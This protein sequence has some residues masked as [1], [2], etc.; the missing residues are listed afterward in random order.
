MLVLI[1]SPIENIYKKTLKTTYFS[2]KFACVHAHSQEINAV[3]RA[4]MLARRQSNVGLRSIAVF[5]RLRGVFMRFVHL[6]CLYDDIANA[7]VYEVIFVL[8]FI[9]GVV[10]C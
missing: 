7:H 6:V 1:Q 2:P 3:K 8:L 4:Q 10:A 5:M 9:L